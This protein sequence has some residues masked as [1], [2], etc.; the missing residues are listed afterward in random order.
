VWVACG[1]AAK[2]AGAKAVEYC[3]VEVKNAGKFAAEVSRRQMYKKY[4]NGFK[5][6]HTPLQ[7]SSARHHYFL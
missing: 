2:E 6:S 5:W 4:E 3:C 7:C 1:I